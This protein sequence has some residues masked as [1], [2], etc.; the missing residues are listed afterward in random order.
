[1]FSPDFD[2]LQ[3][4]ELLLKNQHELAG[5]WNSQAET[6]KQL[7]H[8]NQQLNNMLKMARQDIANLKADVEYLKQR[9]PREIVSNTNYGNH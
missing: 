5:A 7:L 3:Q 6:V 2:P 9:P 1:M 4:L 8:Q